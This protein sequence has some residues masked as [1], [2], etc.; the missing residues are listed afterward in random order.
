MNSYCHS[1]WGCSRNTSFLLTCHFSKSSGG[2]RGIVGGET[3]ASLFFLAFKAP[4]ALPLSGCSILTSCFSPPCSPSAAIVAFCSSDTR[5]FLAPG[6][7]LCRCCFLSLKVLCVAG[8]SSLSRPRFKCHPLGEA[9]PA[10]LIAGCLS[11]PTGLQMPGPRQC[12][13][14]H[15]APHL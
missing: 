10:L 13:S 7:H 3:T 5:V 4:Q 9:G 11:L 8:S 14:L 12:L 6:K 2:E 1:V 15:P